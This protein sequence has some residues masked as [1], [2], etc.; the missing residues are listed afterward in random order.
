MPHP[1]R[2][3]V[4]TQHPFWTRCGRRPV[5]GDGAKI[6]ANGVEYVKANLL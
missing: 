1:E 4:H 6:F 2:H 5:P 3:F